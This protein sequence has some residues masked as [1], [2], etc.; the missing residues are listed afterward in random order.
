MRRNRIIGTLAGVLIVMMIFAFA[1][2]PLRILRNASQAANR[3]SHSHLVR[4]EI[5]DI[6]E[7]LRSIEFQHR[8]FVFTGEQRYRV[9][10]EMEIVRLFGETK[11]VEQLVVDNPGHLRL[12]A[13]LNEKIRNG[14]VSLMSVDDDLRLPMEQKIL[15]RLPFHEKILGDLLNRVKI[16]DQN[17]ATLLAMRQEKLMDSMQNDNLISIVMGFIS[18]TLIVSLF[19]MYRIDSIAKERSAQALRVAN[20]QVERA[21][22][23]KSAFLA[24]MSHEIRTPLGVMLGFADL[25][26]GAGLSDVER[27]KYVDVIRRNGKALS[28]IIN[29]ILD[30]SKVEAGKIAIEKIEFNLTEIL[31]DIADLFDLK[32]EEKGMVFSIETM[33]SLPKTYLSDPTRIRQI[34]INLVSNAM[35]F[36]EHGSVQLHCEWEAGLHASHEGELIFTVTDTGLGMNLDQQGRL[37][38]AFSQADDSIAR[39]YGGTGLGLLLSRRLAR[40]LGGDVELTY[41]APGRGSTFVARIPAYA[42]ISDDRPLAHLKRQSQNVRASQLSQPVLTNLLQD[43]RILLAED[44]PDNQLLLTH[45]LES[46]GAKVSVVSNGRDAVNSALKGDQDLIL[47]DVQMPIMGGH[48]AAHELR[49]KGYRGPIVALTAHAML[50][51]REKSHHYGYNDFL[52]KPID[53]EKLILT[54]KQHMGELH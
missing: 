1:Y 16:L 36:T 39:E 44:A 24:N 32:A 47:M 27:V 20:I 42:S 7:S 19:I 53:S 45:I 26:A 51:E 23:M 48:E 15:Q 31:T 52:T 28:Q 49:K 17:E 4:Q 50:E 21:N 40:L 5:R 12:I 37:F 54:I 46:R 9:L 34:L 43:V 35:K 10:R 13:E 22:E 30:L 18:T 33:G 8:N 25:L 38:Q 14:L 3:V 2:L 6:S 11:D 29:D 41:S